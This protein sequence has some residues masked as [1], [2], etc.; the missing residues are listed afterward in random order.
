MENSQEREVSEKKKEF[1]GEREETGKEDGG[2]PR[3]RVNPREYHVNTPKIANLPFCQVFFKTSRKRMRWTDW[4]LFWL[5]DLPGFL[6]LLW[7]ACILIIVL[8][9]E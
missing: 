7:V 8:I 9:K 2:C 5:N 6:A 3:I 4:W 1:E